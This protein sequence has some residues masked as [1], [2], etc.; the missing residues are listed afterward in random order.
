[1]QI[2]LAAVVFLAGATASPMPQAGAP[3][4][5]T[6]RSYKDLKQG[7][8]YDAA[9][10]IAGGYRCTSIKTDSCSLTS[11][12]SHTV[13]STSDTKGISSSVNCPKGGMTCGLRVTP[14]MIKITGKT[15]TYQQGFNCVNHEKKWEDF[16][17]VAPYEEGKGESKDLRTVMNFEACLEECKGDAC[18]AATEAGLQKCP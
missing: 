1:M 11:S 10:E 15:A 16:E 18:K 5:T 7:K 3:V 14:K 4:C 2:N 12:A 6:E 13:W 9:P 17:V 8:P